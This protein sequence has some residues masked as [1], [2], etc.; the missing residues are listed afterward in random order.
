M[1][2]HAADDQQSEG[3]LETAA[4]DRNFILLFWRKQILEFIEKNK[5]ACT[6]EIKKLQK[7]FPE[8]LIVITSV[9]T[10]RRLIQ[11]QIELIKD[12]AENGMLTEHEQDAIDER[13]DHRL[14]RLVSFR[15]SLKMI[16]LVASHEL[17]QR[18]NGH[19]GDNNEDVLAITV[20]KAD[21]K[22]NI[23]MDALAR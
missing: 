3:K 17:A 16:R 7:A 11:I 2:K 9:L 21:Q 4:E 8:F 1:L 22:Q 15:W 23:A 12:C 5:K 20:G 14:R 10:A 18:L 6:E 19:L 13:L